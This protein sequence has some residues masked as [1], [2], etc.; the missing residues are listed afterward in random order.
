MLATWEL[1]TLI[2]PITSPPRTGLGNIGVQWMLNWSPKSPLPSQSA[3]VY[4]SLPNLTPLSNWWILPIIVQTSSSTKATLTTSHLSSC[5]IFLN[6]TF[7]LRIYYIILRFCFPLLKSSSMK[8]RI[9]VYLVFCWCVQHGLAH[10]RRLIN[11]C[12]IC[13][14]EW[15]FNPRRAG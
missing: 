8:A 11:T 6:N 14:A 12:W 9:F 2:M 1:A 13:V 3:C 4:S 10:S 15:D 7:H 5:L